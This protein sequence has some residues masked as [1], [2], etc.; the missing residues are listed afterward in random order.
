ML[1]QSRRQLSE[2]TSP[3][4]DLPMYRMR[5][6]RLAT[7]AACL[8]L[9]ALSLPASA[10]PSAPD[11]GA[12]LGQAQRFTVKVR[13][14][15]VWPL[16][17]EQAG[18]GLGTGFIIDKDKGWIL[19]NAHVAKK[20]PSTVEIAVG[21]AENEWIPVERIFVDNHLDLAV[22]KVAKDKL[23]EDAVA[24][25]L[26]CKHIVKQGAT[27]VAYG[28]PIS[29]SFTATRGIVSSVR[30]MGAQEYVQMDANI[31]P[32]NSGGPLI[33][34][35]TSEVIGINTLNIPG[36]PGLGLAI[37]IRHVCPIVDLLAAGIEPSVPTLPVYWLKVGRIETLTVAAP[38]PKPAGVVQDGQLKA[39][40]VVQAIAGGP[41]LASVPDLFMALRGKTD[42]VTLTV[43]R[44]GKV[45]DID[46]ALQSGKPPLKRQALI[47]SGLLVS[48]R[49]FLDLA[50]SVL[51]PLR[52]E[53]IK[54]GE[55]AAR[56]G[57]Q[58]GDMLDQ[59][60]GQRFVTVAALH[61]WLKTRAANEKLSVLVRRGTGFD[62]RVVAEYHRFDMQVGEL[63]VLSA[64][65]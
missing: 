20:S 64:G 17:P 29:L 12:M 54:P 4:G 2:L 58:A 60:G 40:D 65:E 21:D 22:L 35:E 38:F 44:D 59:V 53:F 30:T 57:F 7:A 49:Q 11:L 55:P 63:R 45:Q 52:I 33:A 28:H 5:S 41:K 3:A 61:D 6:L 10:Q 9:P 36:A 46:V 47:M 48:D 18:T 25:K 37:A 27:V 1:P 15:V 13:G 42:R 23:P 24:A 14:T 8:F 50:D 19:T 31:N 32:G 43:L 34:A 39:G 16:A 62:P 51:P 56:V 26:G